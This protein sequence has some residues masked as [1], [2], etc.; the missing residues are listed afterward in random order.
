MKNQKENRK[1]VKIG[2]HFS[3]NYFPISA[4]DFNKLRVGNTL[5]NFEDGKTLICNFFLYKKLSDIAP[6]YN[7]VGVFYH[8][9]NNN[10]FNN[11]NYSICFN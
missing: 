2:E 9:L 11:N 8:D 6:S 4:L 3:K 10:L 1:I 7:A 5:S